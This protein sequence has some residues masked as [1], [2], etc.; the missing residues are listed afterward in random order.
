MYLNE[1]TKAVIQAHLADYPQASLIH[2]PVGVGLM[3]IA[4]YIAQQKDAE[5]LVFRPEKDGKVDYE[6]GVVTVDTV[7]AMIATAN[8]TTNKK[9]LIV[10]DT[11]DLMTRGAQNAFLK[12]LEEPNASTYLMLLAHTPSML[13][14]TI[15]SRVVSIEALR[16]SRSASEDILDELKVQD[17][18]KRAQLLFIAEG[19]PEELRKLANDDDYLSA[20]STFIRDAR[21]FIQAHQYQKF[22]IIEK[23]KDD[24]YRATLLLTD[25]AKLL[26]QNVARADNALK[27]IRD[28]VRAIERIQA[29]G[30]VRLCL[31]EL[32]V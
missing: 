17:K 13:L 16:V 25:M 32:V 10:I 19:L 20:R 22:K 2:G 28:I 30:N 24:R 8:L 23:Y 7:R 27:K 3:D 26:S 21:E 4:K 15:H 6:K 29:N 1:R 5:I 9:R 14:P 31:A 11:A 12:L 18:T